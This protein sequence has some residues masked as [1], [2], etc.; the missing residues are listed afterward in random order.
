MH[1][2]TKQIYYTHAHA[3]TSTHTHSTAV[4]THTDLCDELEILRAIEIHSVLPLVVSCHIEGDYLQ[5]LQTCDHAC[6]GSGQ[7]GEGRKYTVSYICYIYLQL[8][9]IQ[10]AIKV[11]Q[12]HIHNIICEEVLSFMA[13]LPKLASYQ[14]VSSKY[15]IIGP[16]RCEHFRATCCT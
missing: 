7:S 15:I 1:T 14:P 4:R 5:L 11:V 13:T 3:H 16:F 10:G 8:T 2:H 12:L 9:L 6:L